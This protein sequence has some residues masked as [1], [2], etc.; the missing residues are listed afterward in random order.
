M[1]LKHNSKCV[2]NVVVW[3][4]DVRTHCEG[5]Q[6]WTLVVEMSI[7]CAYLAW[8][9]C[10]MLRSVCVMQ[11]V[12]ADESDNGKQWH[13]CSLSLWVLL[14]VGGPCDDALWLTSLQLPCGWAMWRC[15]VI[16]KST[17]TVCDSNCTFLSLT[18]TLLSTRFLLLLLT[19][20]PVFGIFW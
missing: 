9:S 7:E 5:W 6:L 13:T 10:A 17:V 11:H 15:I 12:S 2:W 20:L 3:M 1:K 14:S 18:F 4:I 8:D 16:D 19:V